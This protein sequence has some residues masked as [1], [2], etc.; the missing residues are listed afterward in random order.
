MWTSCLMLFCQHQLDQHF[1]RIGC[2]LPSCTCLWWERQR[3]RLV[4][5]LLWCCS[6]FLDFDAAGFGSPNTVGSNQI[7]D[8]ANFAEKDLQ[9]DLDRLELT[10]YMIVIDSD[11]YSG[12]FVYS[13]K[14]VYCCMYHYL[15]CKSAAFGI[16]PWSNISLQMNS[17][18]YDFLLP[19]RI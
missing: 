19:G 4:H 2:S 12:S 8:L 18:T 9:A 16:L 3:R 6:L 17:A 1:G 7:I 10:R 5:V 14:Y 13:C 11:A 15:V